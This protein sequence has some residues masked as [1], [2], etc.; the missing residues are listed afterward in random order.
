M[1]K[2]LYILMT[3]TLAF[4]LMPAKG[5]AANYNGND[6][7]TIAKKYLGVPYKYGGTTTNGFDCSGYLIYVFNQLGI[8]LPRTADEQY[9]KAGVSVEK[10]DLQAGDLVFFSGTTSAK[11]ITHSGIYIGDNNFISATTSKGVAIV[12]LDNTYW[13]PKYTGAKRVINTPEINNSVFKDISKNHFAYNAILELT[14]DGV[15][16]GYTDG[17]F[18]PE[19][20]VTRGQASAIINRVLNHT[21]KSNVSYSDVLP[22]NQFAKDIAAIK[23]LGIINGFG[24]GTFRPNDTMT[25][26]QMAIIVKNAFKLQKPN[27]SISSAS[28]IYSD[29]NPS[30]IF[31]D[32]IITMHAIDRTEGFKT[33][34]YRSN[35]SATRADFSAAIYNGIHAK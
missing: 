9:K 13:K 3:I 24:D 7:V 15:I 19:T 20:S 2:L 18:R 35:D 16:N 28:K 32:G 6:V 30:N 26:G 5:N 34:K 29:V 23:E 22:S 4:T 25:R 10:Q 21:P 31:F 27:I 8:S 11:G 17:T 1:K 33:T 14:A 12:S